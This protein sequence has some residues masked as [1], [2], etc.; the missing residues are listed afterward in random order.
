MR[1]VGLTVLLLLATAALVV[2]TG[3]AGGAVRAAANMTANVCQLTAP[4]AATIK[5][6]LGTPSAPPTFVPNPGAYPDPYCT[7]SGKTAQMR[8]YLKPSSQAATEISGIE[9]QYTSV[10]N[11]MVKKSLGGLGTGATLYYYP[12]DNIFVWFT[13]GSHFVAIVGY[14]SSPAQTETFARAVY[15]RLH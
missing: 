7:V 5:K 3:P 15:A 13:K 11:R 10:Q 14:T 8:I 12:K 9:G 4:S 2:T 1:R 6:D